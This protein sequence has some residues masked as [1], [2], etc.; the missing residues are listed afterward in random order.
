MPEP[1][2]GHQPLKAKS[3]GDGS[4][5]AA[6]II[7]DNR[8]PRPGP[9]LAIAKPKRAANLTWVRSSL[10]RMLRTLALP[11][12]CIQICKEPLIVR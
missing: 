9:G 12:E 7:V 4:I 6:E 11:G 2:L 8:T 10:A 5:G 3:S 1:D